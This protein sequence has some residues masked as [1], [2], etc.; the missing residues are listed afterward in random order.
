MNVLLDI[1]IFLFLAGI[2]LFG[3]FL[4]I[5]FIPEIEQFVLKIKKKFKP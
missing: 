4:L 5:C 3:L 1:L 2:S